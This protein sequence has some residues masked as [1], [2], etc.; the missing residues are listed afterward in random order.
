MIVQEPPR[1]AIDRLRG[2]I[3]EEYGKLAQQPSCGFHF[4]YGRPLAERLGYPKALLDALPGQAVASFAGTGNPFAMGDIEAGAS[5]LDIGSGAGTDALIAAG[6]VGPKGRVLGVDLTDAMVERAAENARTTGMTNARFVQGVAEALPVPDASID[7]VLSNG[8][9]NLCPDKPAVFA[10]I[11]R[12]LKPGGRFQISDT[13]LE[14]PVPL[15]VKDLIHLWTDC[16]A[17]GLPQDEYVV[18]L[19]A[20]GFRTVVVQD[21]YDTFAGAPVEKAAQRYGARGFNLRGYK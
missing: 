3:Q 8:V 5:V 13:L 11:Y 14:K 1:F 12:V 16:V 2:A 18:L 10:E 6:M 9:I 20:A 7:V 15:Y 21:S 4:L 17:G 19:T